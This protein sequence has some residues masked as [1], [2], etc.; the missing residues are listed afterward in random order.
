MFLFKE[1]IPL[2]TFVNQIVL[3]SLQGEFDISRVD[4]EGSLSEQE[5][6]VLTENLHGFLMAVVFNLL[7]EKAMQ[8]KIK[9]SAE[10]I[11]H[12]FGMSIVF[13]YHS[14]GFTADEAEVKAKE[15]LETVFEY[16][17]AVEKVD[18]SAAKE[19]NPFFHMCRHYVHKFMPNFTA[20]DPEQVDKHFLAFDI[21]N[22]VY[23]NTKQAFDATL[24]KVNVVN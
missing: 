8:R 13:A 4:A 17:A 24:K 2:A 5:K 18:L 12:K 3:A 7:L 10:E 22:Q 14:L 19:K 16:G 1:K 20:S 23:Q 11:G 6:S 9:V 21:A 15:M